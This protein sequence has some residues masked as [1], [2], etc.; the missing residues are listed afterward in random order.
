MWIG[1]SVFG[2]VVFTILA[3]LVLVQKPPGEDRFVV[4]A[5]VALLFAMLLYGWRRGSLSQ[6]AACVLTAGLMLIEL[7]NSCGYY[8]PNRDEKNRTTYLKKLQENADLAQVL[9]SLPWPARF[10]VPTQE[11]PFNFGDWYGIDQ[12]GG[13]LASLPA[14]LVRF[15]QNNARVMKMFGVNY[16]VTRSPAGPNQQEVFA[17][18]SGLKLYWNADALP[19]TW[20]VHE[21]VEAHN[22]VEAIGFINDGNFDLRK[23]VFLFSSPPQL[24]TCNGDEY[25]RMLTR[26][27]ASLV[28]EAKLKCRGMVLVGD[29]YFPGWQATVDGKPAKIF[30]AN[31]MIRAVVVDAGR[32]TIEMKYRP[33]SV[34]LGALMTLAGFLGASVLWFGPRI[35]RRPS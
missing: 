5:F 11:I 31:G 3:V 2:A 4:N 16:S 33:R 27:S 15:D 21:A 26:T 13:Y 22:D 7:N 28:V 29:S 23:K 8:W 9:R 10:E 30:E 14:N 34:Y 19:R 35:G 18:E 20:A 32:H 24:E 1:L 6:T 17:A 25:V 12:Y